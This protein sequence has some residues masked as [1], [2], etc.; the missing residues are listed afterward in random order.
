MTVTISGLLLVHFNVPSEPYGFAFSV[1]VSRSFMVREVSSR[2]IPFTVI[3][4]GAVLLPEIAVMPALPVATPLTSPVALFTV[5][6]EG[7][8]LLQVKGAPSGVTLAVS[9]RVCPI[10]ISVTAGGSMDIPGVTA[11]FTVISQLALPISPVPLFR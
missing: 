5:A 8:S 7:L 1:W 6:T 2:R 9:W 3:S 4:Q 11:G 10:S